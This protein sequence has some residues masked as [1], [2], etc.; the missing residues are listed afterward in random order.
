M[1]DSKKVPIL[2]PGQ[3]KGLGRLETLEIPLVVS[4]CVMCMYALQWTALLSRLY[5][6]PW[7]DTCWRYEQTIHPV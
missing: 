7:P 6:Q 3:S 2:S 1:V 5:S 4:E